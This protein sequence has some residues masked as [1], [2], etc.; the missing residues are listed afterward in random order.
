[1]IGGVGECTLTV[2]PT[3]PTSGKVDPAYL[4]AGHTDLVSDEFIEALAR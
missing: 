1:M 4:P 2:A 3:C